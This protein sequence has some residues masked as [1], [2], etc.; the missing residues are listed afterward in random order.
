MKGPFQPQ[1]LKL[2]GV[3]LTGNCLIGRFCPV[4]AGFSLVPVR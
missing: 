1:I 2:T 4:A 3:I